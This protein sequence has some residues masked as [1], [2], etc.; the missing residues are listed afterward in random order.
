[1]AGAGAGV[2]IGAAV[3]EAEGV[4]VAKTG[5]A[6]RRAW[7]GR[8]AGTERSA[9]G[10]A[11]A[12]GIGVGG[13]SGVAVGVGD[14]AR[15]KRSGITPGNVCGRCEGTTTGLGLEVGAS[16][17][18]ASGAASVAAARPHSQPVLSLPAFTAF[19]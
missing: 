19:S 6:S 13:G 10:V 14:G 15:L 8:A 12:V 9:A 16:W 11:R 7:M 18:R 5:A 2:A 1:M 17:A 3:G 4:G